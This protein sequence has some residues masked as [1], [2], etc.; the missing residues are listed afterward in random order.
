MYFS[1]TNLKHVAND[2]ITIRMQQ[3]VLFP[4]CDQLILQTDDIWLVCDEKEMQA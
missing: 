4:S 3:G 2:C 1:Q